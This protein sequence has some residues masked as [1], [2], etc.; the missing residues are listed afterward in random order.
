VSLLDAVVNVAFV[1][2]SFWLMIYAFQRGT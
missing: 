1:G 2:A